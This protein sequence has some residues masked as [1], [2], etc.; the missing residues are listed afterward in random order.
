MKTPFSIKQIALLF[1]DIVLL[2][3]SLWLAL[4]IRYQALPDSLVWA[5]HIGPFTIVFVIWVIAYYIVDLYH[6]RS[7]KNSFEFN[8]KWGTM[9]LINTAIALAIFYFLPTD[10]N[11]ATFAP[12]TNLLLFAIVFGVI[13]FIWRR[14]F[15]TSL[16]RGTPAS[17]VFFMDD[18]PIADEL[19]GHI[20]HNHQLG[21][22]LTALIQNATMIVTPT[23][24]TK[25]NDVKS[26]YQYVARGIDI[27]DLHSFYS[28]IFQKIPLQELHELR[29]L[30]DVTHRH[31]LYQTAKRLFELVTA[32]VLGIILIIPALLIALLIKITS[33]GPILFPHTRV[34]QH[35]KPFTIYKF[36]SMY[37]DAEKDGPQWASAHDPRVTPFG[38]LLRFTHL[39]EMP[40]LINIIRGELSFVGPRPERPEFIGQLQKGIPYYDLRHL[41]RPGLTGWAQLH[42]RYG[43]STHDAYKKLEYDLYYLKNCSFWLDVSV[44]IKTIRLLF[45]NN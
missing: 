29:F 22:A 15:N 19:I 32:I 25:S 31:N 5:R 7:L 21:Y 40:Q 30:E 28:L 38:R 23:H 9:L 20:R 26:M 10:A 12:K 36:R 16:R 18:G 39:D 4:A 44:L 1:G 37:H 13:G 11:F 34:G 43:A 35:G 24:A 8:R 2:Y 33:R 3:A 6:F 42:Y 17:A 27:I 14:T 45:T 41:V